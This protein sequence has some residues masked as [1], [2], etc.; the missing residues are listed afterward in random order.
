MTYDRD[1]FS[2]PGRFFCLRSIAL[3]PETQGS[4]QG[5]TKLTRRFTVKVPTSHQQVLHN[6]IVLC[7]IFKIA[8]RR[9][10]PDFGGLP[11]RVQ[12]RGRFRGLFW[13]DTLSLACSI[14]AR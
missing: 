9:N 12:N 4:F 11:F 2:E 7:K 1:N 13:F 6:G 5:H 14:A 8:G 10:S 3:E